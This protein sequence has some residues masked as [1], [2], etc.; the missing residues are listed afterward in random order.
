VQ[1]RIWDKGSPE[2]EAVVTQALS[3]ILTDLGFYLG[4]FIVV[5]H[6]SNTTHAVTTYP[7][8]WIDTYLD[9]DMYGFDPRIQPALLANKPVDWQVCRIFDTVGVLNIHEGLG[10][11][12]HGLS[13]PMTGLFGDYALLLVSKDCGD[14]EW[15][16]HKDRTL[17]ELT[18]RAQQIRKLAIETWSLENIHRDDPLTRRERQILELLALVGDRSEIAERLGLSKRTIETH[19]T[20]ARQK[21]NVKTTIQAVAKIS[22]ERRTTFSIKA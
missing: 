4:D 13:I 9:N 8:Q 1:E 16:A 20:T 12:N 22:S 15:Q 3:S 21:L 14:E 5:P 18:R 11:G 10:C 19:L 2:Q 17:D 6:R 7:K